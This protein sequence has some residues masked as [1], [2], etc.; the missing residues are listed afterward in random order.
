MSVS[1]L[2]LLVIDEDSDWRLS[3][4]LPALLLASENCE[5]GSLLCESASEPAG[6]CLSEAHAL[7]LAA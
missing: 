1:C 3:G 6:E 2:R 7:A 4:T 5:I